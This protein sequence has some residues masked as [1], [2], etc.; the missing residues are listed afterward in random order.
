LYIGFSS[1]IFPSSSLPTLKTF[2]TVGLIFVMLIIGLEVD[3][4]RVKNNFVAA[5]S[6][7]SSGILIPFVCGF[8]LGYWLY[9]FEV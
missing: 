4:S 3:P 7:A 9:D 6:I 1:T 8:A 5:F 2:A